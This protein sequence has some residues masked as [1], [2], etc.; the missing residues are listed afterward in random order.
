MNDSVGGKTQDSQKAN[1][2]EWAVAGGISLGTAIAIVSPF[3]FFGMASGHDI[4][5]HMASWLDAASQWKQGIVFPRWTEWANFGYG[6]PRFIFYPPLSWMFGA[7]LGTLIP[8]K[9]VGIA[10]Y[11]CVQTFAGLSAYALLRQISDSRR[12]ARFATLCFVMNPYALTIIYARSDFAELLAISF[13]PVLLLAA[14]RLCGIFAQHRKPTAQTL[15][16]AIVFCAV[17]LSNAPSAV[18]A[19]YGVAF[20]FAFSSL[21][22]R[23]FEP[24]I[25]GAA[26]IL[27]GFG[28][29]AF[30]IVPAAYEQRWVKIAGALASG[31]EPAQNF[32]YAKTSDSEHDLFN[33]IASN[34][35]VMLVAWTLAGATVAWKALRSASDDQ[36]HAM[37]GAITALAAAAT[38]LMLPVTSLLWRYLPELRFV[39]FPW[40]WMSVIALCAVVFTAASMKGRFEWIWLLV[41][42]VSIAGSGSYLGNHTW[43]DT[44]DMPSLETALHEGTGFEGTDEYDPVG[45]DNSDLPLKHP[46]ARFVRGGAGGAQHREIV[47]PGWTAEHRRLLVVTPEAD[48]V[49]VRLLNYPAWRV[50]VNGSPALVQHAAGTAQMIIP[51]PAGSSHIEIEFTRTLDRT[52]GGWIS[53]LAAGGSVGLWLWRRQRR[54]RLSGDPQPDGER[55]APARCR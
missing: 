4:A 10:F 50:T 15:A 12:T 14:L 34:I 26:G 41:A 28:L 24:L 45:D 55:P 11:A 19:T 54:P 33:R 8:W 40:R 27:L 46:R 5:F 22:T 23:T 31:L 17:W 32:L 44:E 38:L 2:R 3:F 43:W 29:A 47:V 42:T 9:Y 20:L 36:P 16:F 1:L 18:I 51:V 52:V 25:K 6:E 7:L 30:Y 48:L 37:L 35:A 21:Q 49:A 53:I 13:F 39:Q